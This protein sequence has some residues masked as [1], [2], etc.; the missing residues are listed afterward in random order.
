MN[1][2]VAFSVA[3]RAAWDTISMTY[4]FSAW[5]IIPIGFGTRDRGCPAAPRSSVDSCH[6][7]TIGDVPPAAACCAASTEGNCAAASAH[8]AVTRA[9]ATRIF[10]LLRAARD[11]FGS[12]VAFPHRAL[13]LLFHFLPAEVDAQLPRLRVHLRIVDRDDVDDV[14]GRA[15]GPALDH[16]HFVGMKGA[17]DGEPGLI[18]VVGDVDDQRVLLPV[19]ARIAH[20][21]L[22][23]VAD[24][25]T[26]VQRNHA[27]AVMVVIG[28][29]D[30]AGV[31]LDLERAL[32]VD[33]RDAVLEP[34][35]HR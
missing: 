21:H 10:L 6:V 15:D 17:D 25:R 34:A 18:G 26:A 7:P 24:V 22:D 33:A 31:L 16:A 9:R 19:T 28:D 4:P 35:A 13:P 11:Y 23:S 20:P 29:H 30:S 5:I 1:C 8:K 27:V 32:V 14:V 3:G 12:L 2:S